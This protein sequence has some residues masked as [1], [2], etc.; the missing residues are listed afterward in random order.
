MWGVF[1]GDTLEYPFGQRLGFDKRTSAALKLLAIL[2]ALWLLNV[3]FVAIHE[4]GHTAMAAAFG[5]KI[6]NVYVSV[7]GLEGATTHDALPVQSRASLVIAAGIVATTAA[8]VIA[9][10]ARFE[11]AVYVLGLRTIESLLNYSA[12][13]DMLALLGNIG[14]DAYLFSAVMIGISALCTGLT[15]RRRMGLI[16]SAEQAKR[17]AIAAPV[18]AV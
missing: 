10:L 11:L 12:G 1:N 6:Y 4:G 9:F 14:T 13:S 5:A 18:A 16:R 17:Q 8:L 7:T 3:G 2:A 15:I